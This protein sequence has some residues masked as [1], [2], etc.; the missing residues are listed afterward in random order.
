MSQGA[1]NRLVITRLA[2]IV[3]VASQTMLYQLAHLSFG[4][5]P[6]YVLIRCLEC[7]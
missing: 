2:G 6:V 5:G 3:P 4:Y 7:A 1:K